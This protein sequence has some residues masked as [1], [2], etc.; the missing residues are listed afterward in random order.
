MKIK[1]ENLRK[2]IIFCSYNIKG[3]IKDVEIRQLLPI[4]CNE[5]EAYEDSNKLIIKHQNK[6]IGEILMENHTYS[7]LQILRLITP[8]YGVNSKGYGI[9]DVIH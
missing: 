4:K 6:I 3:L 1:D 5:L 7:N 8:I 9:L 2:L